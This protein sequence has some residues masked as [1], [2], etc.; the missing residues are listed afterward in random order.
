MAPY[1]LPRGRITGRFVH[2]LLEELPLASLSNAP[3]WQTWAALPEVAAVFERVRRRYDR[4]PVQIPVAQQLVHTALSA[5]V[6]LGGVVV[7][8][9]ARAARSLRELEFIYPIPEPSHP[10]LVP[11]PTESLQAT[12]A[13][14]AGEGGHAFA[15]G[16]GIIKGYI[17]LLFE[18][19]G[20]VYLCD[21]KGDWLP[22]WDASTVAAHVQSNYTLQAQLYTV[23][24][25]RFL[26]IEG[27]QAFAQRFGGVVYAFV[28]GMALDDPTRGIFFAQ[29]SYADV[30]TWQAELL[31]DR[32]WGLR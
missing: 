28:R 24:V 32:F 26:G 29:P 18:H 17:D 3:D 6:R 10:L 4:S 14:L 7:P 19:Q 22:A 23:G 15:I 11:A 8:G 12:N 5:Q 25:L 30:L 21:W 20:L 13:Q 16:R 31:D 9:L 2:A 1:E 27:P